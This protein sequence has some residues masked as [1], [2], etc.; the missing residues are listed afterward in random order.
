MYLELHELQPTLAP[1]ISCAQ[2]EDLFQLCAGRSE[3]RVEAEV[4]LQTELTRRGLTRQAA[5]EESRKLTMTALTLKGVKEPD[6]RWVPAV[7]AW[8]LLSHGTGCE[9]YICDISVNVVEA[10]LRGQ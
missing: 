8:D 2:T 9:S 5:T 7:S 1:S 4:A 3:L 6:A 10:E